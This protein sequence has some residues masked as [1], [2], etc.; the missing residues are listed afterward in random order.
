ME[1]GQFCP[2]AKAS[3]IIGEKWTILIIR[4][5]L[6]GARRFTDLQRGLGTIS[7]TLLTRRLVYLEDRGMLIKK[8]IQGQK[9]YEY[10]PTESCQGLLPIILALGDWG[11]QW[12]R[13]NLSTRD[14]DVNLLMLYLQRSIMGEKLPHGKTVIRFKFTD[15]NE[16]ADWWLI[17]G[18]AGTD[19]C[20]KDPGK[21]V[22][23]F[24]TTTVMTMADIWMGETTYRKAMNADKLSIVGPGVLVNNVSNWMSN[25]IFTELPS[26]RDI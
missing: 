6:M 25:S 4:E 20:D 11:M 8:K 15:M 24:F 26:A 21:D 9:G 10:L 14:Y 17:A 16:K 7:P 3:E 13:A 2:V 23:V 22:D 12:A 5:L 1:Y 19:I 18:E